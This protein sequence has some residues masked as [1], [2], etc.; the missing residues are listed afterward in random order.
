[1][2]AADEG[3]SLLG[4]LRGGGAAGADC[5]DWFVSNND[6]LHRVGGEPGE[7]GGDLCLQHGVGAA[8]IALFELFADAENHLEAG[9]ESGVY[10]SVDEVVALAEHVPAFAVAENDVAAAQVEKHGRADLAGESPFFFRIEI[11]SAERDF[12]ATHR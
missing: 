12:S 7:A 10:F 3:M 6:V 9:G 1:D 8:G 11:L 4:L 5:P 2:A